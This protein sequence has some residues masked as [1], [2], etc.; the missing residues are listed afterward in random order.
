MSETRIIKVGPI[1]ETVQYVPWRNDANNKKKIFKAWWWWSACLPS[2]P[3]MWV[4]FP[5]KSTVFCNHCWLK[6]NKNEVWG[7]VYLSL[8]TIMWSRVRVL[9]TPSNIALY[10]SLYWEKDEYKQ[11]EAGLGPYLKK[12]RNGLAQFFKKGKTFFLSTTLSSSFIVGSDWCVCVVAWR[13]YASMASMQF[14]VVGA[15]GV[16]IK[17]TQ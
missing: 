4:R 5:K 12:R 6:I 2:I 14:R 17:S 15:V 10:L 7:S 3:T 1:C 11:K 8:P 9:S 16:I 13:N